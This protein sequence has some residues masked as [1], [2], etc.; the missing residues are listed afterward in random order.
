MQEA[1]PKPAAPSAA[2]LRQY[3][4]ENAA[5]PLYRTR[6][7]FDSRPPGPSATQAAEHSPRPRKQR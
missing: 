6:V 1:G 5:T 7:L 4:Y 3:E 2:D